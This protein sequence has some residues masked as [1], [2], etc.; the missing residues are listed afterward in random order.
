MNLEIVLI[1]ISSLS[2]IFSFLT[3]GFAFK[4][5]IEVKAMQRS[6]HAV[7][8]VPIDPEIDKANDE[9]MRKEK[10]REWAT[11]SKSIH[12]QNEMYK[13]QIEDN[14]PEFVLSEDD[15]EI[16]SL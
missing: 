2:F 10:E 12:K 3:V 11:S 7:E 8:Y 5:L 4:A 14:L 6:T 1:I 9:Y 13:E 16:Y 15:K